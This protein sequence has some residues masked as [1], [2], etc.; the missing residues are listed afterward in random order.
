MRNVSLALTY[1]HSSAH[2]KRCFP[3]PHT[4]FMETCSI[5]TLIL[6][7]QLWRKMHSFLSYFWFILGPPWWQNETSVWGVWWS[8]YN[9]LTRY[10]YTVR[11]QSIGPY[12]HCRDPNGTRILTNHIKAEITAM[13]FLL[14]YCD[15]M[16]REIIDCPIL[17]WWD[18]C[19]GENL[20]E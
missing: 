2:P 7:E 16:A 20:R 1:S 10:D 15:K 12:G 9:L 18:A 19:Q 3:V 6:N 8:I 11:F 5:L 4:T 13:F 17:K 14:A